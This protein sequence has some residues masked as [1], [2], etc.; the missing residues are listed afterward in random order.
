MI[1]FVATAGMG[2]NYLSTNINSYGYETLCTW[3][4]RGMNNN[5]L[6]GVVIQL[7]GETFQEGDIVAKDFL[8]GEIKPVCDQV[9][10]V[11]I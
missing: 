4:T 5:Y 6:K 1:T 2:I 11:I 3:H 10:D 7:E 9:V 8:V